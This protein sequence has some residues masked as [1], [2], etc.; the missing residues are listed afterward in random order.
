MASVREQILQ[1]LTTTLAATSGVRAVYRS[2]AEA[3]GR[4]EAPVLVIQPGPG[5]AVRHTT[6]KLHHTLDVEVIVHTRGA[7]PDS[8]ADPIIVSAHALIMAD[9]TIGGLAV[10]IVPTNSD[11]QI[12]PGDLSSMWWVHTYEVQYRTRDAD[13]TQA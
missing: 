9:T 12:D 3:F 8:L 1:S 6:C 2:R 10:D 11:P 13:L 4:S 5:R 7:T